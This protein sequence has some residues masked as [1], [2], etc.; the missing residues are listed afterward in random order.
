MLRVLSKEESFKM[1]EESFAKLQK[2]MVIDLF[3]DGSRMPC[4]VFDIDT[5]GR[6]FWVYPLT[7]EVCSLLCE[8]GLLPVCSPP[9]EVVLPDT[10]D[11][12]HPGWNVL[13]EQL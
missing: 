3:N 12:E 13:S 6:K 5:L 4:V 7:R 8:D 11:V 1:M 9:I 10:S 2:Y